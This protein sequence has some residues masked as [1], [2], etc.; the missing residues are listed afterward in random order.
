MAY[1]CLWCLSAYF[2]SL[3]GMKMR[4]NKYL[5]LI[6]LS[7]ILIYAVIFAIIVA[8]PTGTGEVGWEADFSDVSNWNSGGVDSFTTDGDIATITSSSKYCHI[9]T[10]GFSSNL[11]QYPRVAIRIKV[12]RYESKYYIRFEGEDAEGNSR[13]IWWEEGALDDLIGTDDWV[14]LHA[15]LKEMT[16]EAKDYWRYPTPAIEATKVSIVSYSPTNTHHIEVDWIK[17]YNLVIIEQAKYWFDRSSPETLLTPLCIILAVSGIIFMR[18]GRLIY[19]FKEKLSKLFVAT[20]ILYLVVAAV[21]ASYNLE[22]ARR[23]IDYTF[24][25][26]V[27]GALLSIIPTRASKQN[28]LKQE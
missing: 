21:A 2:I 9:V 8:A 1:K 6:A 12:V 19:N 16:K 18:K 10:S 24:W 11:A 20:F 27:T 4:L 28:R 26:L 22:T 25:L 7:T 14:I 5:V 15:N 13:R 17:I 3:R 23:I